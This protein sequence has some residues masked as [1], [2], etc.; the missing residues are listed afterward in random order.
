[1]KRGNLS[2]KLN[3]KFKT[4]CKTVNVRPIGSTTWK[5]AGPLRGADQRMQNYVKHA[6][7]LVSKLMDRQVKRRRLP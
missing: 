6:R 5:R 4:R 2:K 3:L 1:M 7:D